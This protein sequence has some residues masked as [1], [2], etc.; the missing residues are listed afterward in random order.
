MEQIHLNDTPQNI[1]DILAGTLDDDN[2]IIV[3]CS[4]GGSASCSD[5]CKDGCKE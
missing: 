3:S 4:V 5:S 1:E 2:Y